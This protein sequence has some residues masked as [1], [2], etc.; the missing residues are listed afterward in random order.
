LAIGGDPHPGPGDAPPP[1]GEPSIR[2]SD[3]L[4]A[5][6]T[7]EATGLQPGHPA[8]MPAQGPGAPGVLTLADLLRDSAPHPGP[9][10]WPTPQA[11]WGSPGWPTVDASGTPLGPPWQEWPNG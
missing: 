5:H 3:L 1:A 9:V 11:P 6:P 2:W 8:A 4:D 10:P 7:V